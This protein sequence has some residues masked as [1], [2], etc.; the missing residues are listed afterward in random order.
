[1]NLCVAIALLLIVFAVGVDSTSNRLGCQIVAGLL[2][3]LTLVTVFWM[4]I[5][6]YNL[7]LQLVKVMAIYYRKFMLKACLV[8][9][10]V[11]AIIVIATVV[12]AAIEYNANEDSNRVFYYGNKNV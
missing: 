5:E 9:W 12:A 11:P 4:G 6:A 8:A 10:G 2:H 1:M 3:Y 7:Y